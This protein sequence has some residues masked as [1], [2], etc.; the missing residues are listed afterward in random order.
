MGIIYKRAGK[1][2]A[3]VSDLKK[4]I[5]ITGMI[6]VAYLILMTAA[7]PAATTQ[8][9]AP[10]TSREGDAEN[11]YII[12]V[13]EGRVTVFRGEDTVV[14]TETKLSDLPKSDRVKLEE[15][16]Y[17]DSLKELKERLEDYCS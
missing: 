7:A 17:I 3:E 9:T 6:L 5:I 4:L 12:G 13:S 8:D 10:V 14:R 11:G 15:G 16:I 1:T 2:T